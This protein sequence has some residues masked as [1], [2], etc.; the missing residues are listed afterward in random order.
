MRRWSGW[1]SWTRGVRLPD[2][3][4]LLRAITSV[5]ERCWPFVLRSTYE[6]HMKGLRSRIEA[7]EAQNARERDQLRQARYWKGQ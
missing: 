5:L 7:L 6:N 4:D 1:L 2:S 3:R